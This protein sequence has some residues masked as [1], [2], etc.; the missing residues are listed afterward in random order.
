MQLKQGINIACKQI[1]MFI[2]WMSED[3][4]FMVNVEQYS[5]FSQKTFFFTSFGEVIEIIEKTEIYS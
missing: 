2:D 5:W 3:S 4:I 1:S